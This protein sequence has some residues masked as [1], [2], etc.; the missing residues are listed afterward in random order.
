MDSYPDD[1]EALEQAPE[2]G[3]SPNTAAWGSFAGMVGWAISAWTLA[4][5]AWL[6]GVSGHSQKGLP[7]F[8][9]ICD[10]GHGFVF[11]LMVTNWRDWAKW[12]TEKPGWWNR[13]PPEYVR[14][15]SR[16]FQTAARF[17]TPLVVLSDLLVI[18]F[19]L[20]RL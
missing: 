2:T 6:E 3:P 17:V 12:L 15:E 18:G 16:F 11:W 20:V 13:H 10:I 5:V 1:D 7:L 19:V 14:P 4:I 9:A 8:F